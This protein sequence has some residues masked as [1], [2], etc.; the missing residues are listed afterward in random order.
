M[1]EQ[2]TIYEITNCLEYIK[3]NYG[4]EDKEDLSALE[5]ACKILMY[6]FHKTETVQEL[7]T[8]MVVNVR[9]CKEDIAN[10][11][12]NQ[13]YEATEENIS[14]V[15]NYDSLAD[16]IDAVSVESG[17]EVIQNVI[18]SIS[19]SLTKAKENNNNVN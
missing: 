4:I 1:N 2:Q 14:K 16:T 7:T 18:F 17:W 19:N 11:L 15:Y 3:N 6:Q 12:E 10:C 9:W 13:G 5:N 8:G